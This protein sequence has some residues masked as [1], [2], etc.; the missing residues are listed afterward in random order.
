[1]KNCPSCGALIEDNIELC[2]E[3]RN[4]N[5]KDSIENTKDLTN[6]LLNEQ[7]STSSKENDLG[8]KKNDNLEGNLTKSFKIPTKEHDE[9]EGNQT[10]AF[11]IISDKYQKTEVDQTRAFKVR[12]I[13]D[14][15]Q[16]DT[17][18]VNSKK[19]KIRKFN[20]QIN[21]SKDIDINKNERIK[22][23]TGISVNEEIKENKEDINNTDKIGSLI[24]LKKTDEYLDA[25]NNTVHLHF[26]DND[27]I[28]EDK[29]YKDKN[30]KKPIKAKKGNKLTENKNN[31]P[32]K[33][34]YIKIAG[35][36]IA[37][38]VIISVVFS[39]NIMCSFYIM[40]SNSSTDSSDKI[41]YAIKAIQAKNDSN[42]IDLLKN[43]FN[44]LTNNDLSNAESQLNKLA[45]TLD[46]SDYNTVL[47]ILK[48]KKI[49]LYVS[50]SKYEEAFN[51]LAA[52]NDIGVDFKQNENYDDIMLNIIATLTGTPVTGNKGILMD[53]SSICYD[54]FDEDPFD[55]IIAVTENVAY[56]S[57]PSI[58]VNLY[59][60]SGSKYRL[61]SSDTLNNAY[62][63]GI[64]GVYEYSKD[65]KGVYI[66]YSSE[67]VNAFATSV[68]SV[69]NNN[70]VLKGTV[71]G[72]NYTKPDDP[73]NDGIYEIIANNI[74][75]DSNNKDGDS[76]YYRINDD[77]SA[78]KEVQ[79]S[80]PE[81]SEFKNTEDY[82]F[83]NSDKE[84][85]TDDDLKNLSKEELAYA[86]N[87]IFARHGYQF[88]EEPF[89][90]Y[91]K[92]KSWY[93]IDNSYKGGDSA[94]NKYEIANYKLIQDY[95]SK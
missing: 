7:H 67:T 14:D 81:K 66:H 55:E 24:D 46:E 75:Y 44:S 29:N 84:F 33:K 60:Y 83:E 21:S 26:E 68:Y 19:V 77:N 35:I 40:Q 15:N 38:L 58:K 63:K 65:K 54:N 6:T 57:D 87:E 72:S 2:Q 30:L 36:I 94:L 17:K 71:Y 12:D 64:Q 11:K 79:I 91:F 32:N 51:E 31:I 76:K 89:K 88:K 9:S 90:S 41:D 43:T 13:L 47:K 92:S 82:F 56:K 69:S 53:D 95:E 93:N 18:E 74:S 70:L 23:E 20:K 22:S 1:M 52:L 39:K 59:K 42:T 27:V 50:E 85:L 49:K 28:Y 34:K 3:C 86:R 61:Y 73:D 37:L 4:K 5:D 8:T 80:S 45:N 48:E 10:K 62:D 78:P 25:L 16:I